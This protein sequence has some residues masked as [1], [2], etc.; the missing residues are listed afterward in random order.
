M[1][2]TN[3]KPVKVRQIVYLKRFSDTKLKPKYIRHYTKRENCNK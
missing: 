2:S 1:A 3:K